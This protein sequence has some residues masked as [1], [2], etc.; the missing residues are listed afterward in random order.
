MLIHLEEGRLIADFDAAR[1]ATKGTNILYQPFPAPSPPS[2]GTLL[3]KLQA[4]E[5]G[6][7]VAFFIAWLFCAWGAGFWKLLW[8][9]I[10]CGML[11]FAVMTGISLVHRGLEKEVER[12][13]YDLHRQRGQAYSPPVPES[14]EWLNGL[15]KLV[16]GVI[17]P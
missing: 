8:R 5:I 3:S 13:R 10:I 12:V 2:L 1:P 16:W 14:V 17:D 4:L 9:S 15:I 7:G 11:G 6:T